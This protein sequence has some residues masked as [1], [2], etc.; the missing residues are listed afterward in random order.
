MFA[1]DR[2]SQGQIQAMLLI[3]H[4]TLPPSFKHFLPN[5]NLTA[6]AA[7]IFPRNAHLHHSLLKQHG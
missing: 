6:V 1:Y 2:D 3:T 7:Q 4:M 5:T